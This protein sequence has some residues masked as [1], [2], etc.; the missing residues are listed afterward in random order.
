MAETLS[1]LPLTQPIKLKIMGG[2]NG[3]PQTKGVGKMVVGGVKDDKF[4][5]E[6]IITWSNTKGVVGPYQWFGWQDAMF[7]GKMLKYSFW[8]KFVNSVPA[9]SG[10]FGMKV[11]GM[12]HNDFLKGCS[13][14]EWCYVEKTVKCAASGDGNHVILI[15]DSIARKQKVHI[16]KFQVQILGGNFIFMYTT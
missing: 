5:S 1:A 10:N 15:F 4:R 6:D 9:V 12:V 16:S 2:W 11:Y 3:F 13:A 7:S 8:I 14:N